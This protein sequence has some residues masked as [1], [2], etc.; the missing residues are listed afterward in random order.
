MF[1]C[2]EGEEK[3][4]DVYLWILLAAQNPFRNLAHELNPAMETLPAT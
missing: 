3:K 4:V 1:N 2:D